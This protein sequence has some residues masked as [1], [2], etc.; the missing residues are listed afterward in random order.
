MGGFRY[1]LDV[2]EIWAGYTD[3]G[4]MGIMASSASGMWCVAISKKRQDAGGSVLM[5][6]LVRG[7]QKQLE[8]GNNIFDENKNMLFV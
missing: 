1:W 8:T 4:L 3:H 2:S 7:K 6:G 5:V